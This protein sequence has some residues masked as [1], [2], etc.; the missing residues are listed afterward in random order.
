VDTIA[1]RSLVVAADEAEPPRGVARVVR[2]LVGETASLRR[3]QDDGRPLR[4]G[5]ALHRAE[6]R[7]RL[8]HHP[9]AAAIGRVVGRGHGDRR[10]KSA[11][12]GEAP[13]VSRPRCMGNA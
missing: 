13:I 11:D 8:H 12:P 5:E 2:H 6:D 1:R 10:R 4:Q 9:H 7:L 3:H